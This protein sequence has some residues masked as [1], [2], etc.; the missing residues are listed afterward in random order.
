MMARTLSRRFW[1]L[2]GIEVGM[3]MGVT[4]GRWAPLAAWPLIFIVLVNALFGFLADF[5]AERNRLIK[6]VERKLGED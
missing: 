6:E 3:L 5:F 4:A 2:I 1:F